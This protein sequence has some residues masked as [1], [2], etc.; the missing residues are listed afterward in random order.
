M[1]ITE[2]SVYKGD[3]YK[4]ELEDG[5]TFFINSTVVNDFMLRKGEE[6]SGDRLAQLQQADTRRKAKKRA[7]Y[8]LGTKQYCYNELYKKLKQTYNEDAARSAA[9]SMRDYG[10]VNDEEYAPKLA[11]YLIHTKRYGLRKAKYEMLH[12][13]LSAELVEN[14]LAE[15][16]DE[17]IYE[18]ITELLERKYYNKIA[19]YDD[20]R[21]TIA[22]LARRG[23]DYNSVKHCIERL[24]EDYE[25]YEENED[26]D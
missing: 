6:L 1:E 22:A 3:T 10:Y 7:L 20:R 21:R 19:D 25:D 16:S 8:L 15:F 11:D 18:E 5:Q 17:E 24:L 9:D 2:L 13:G 4:L 12:R 14:T 26:F 23:Y